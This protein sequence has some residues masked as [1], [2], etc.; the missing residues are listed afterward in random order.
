[1]SNDFGLTG[2]VPE[3]VQNDG[4]NYPLIYWLNTTKLGG[5]VGAWHTSS[6]ETLPEP[7]K[8]TDRFANEENGHD[9]QKLTFVPL[10]MREQWYMTIK[11]GAEDKLMAIPHYLDK[12]S[13]PT[14]LAKYG[15]KPEVFG[16]VR[17]TTQMMAMVQDI[18][19]PVIIQAKGLVGA[20]VFKR[21]TRRQPG[22]IVSAYV[23]SCLAVANETKKSDAPI[24]HFSFWVTLETPKDAKGRII[25]TEVGPGAI[26]I[27][28]RLDVDPAT[29]TREHLIKRYIGRDKQELA[30]VMYKECEAWSKEYR[31]DFAQPIGAPPVADTPPSAPR[32][33]PEGLFESDDDKPF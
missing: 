6:W 2:Y 14:F 22:G 18:D 31:D 23:N 24:P 4:D 25:T 13:A 26:I 8:Q 17:S 19:E 28:P 1:M 15:M 11:G 29:I 7:W 9:T 20:H 5:V 3:S 10:R 21:A 12:T 16:G 30:L 27:K 33:A 32:N